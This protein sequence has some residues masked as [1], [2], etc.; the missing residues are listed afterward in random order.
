[1]VKKYFLIASL[2]P[3]LIFGAYLYQ[4]QV[5]EYN[6]T[7]NT[8][9]DNTFALINSRIYDFKVL[10]THLLEIFASDPAIQNSL[11]PDQSSAEIQSIIDRFDA[12]YSADSSMA[13]GLENGSMYTK[14]KALLP[15]DYDPRVRPWYTLTK[16]ATESI[17]LSDPYENA[18]QKSAFSITFSSK[19]FSS[20]DG[21]FIGVAGLDVDMKG[22]LDFGNTLNFPEKTTFFLTDTKGTIIAQVGPDIEDAPRLLATLTLASPHK[23]SSSDHDHRLLTSAG[24]QYAFHYFKNTDTQWYVVAAVEVPLFSAN[25]IIILS[26]ASAIII[27]MTLISIFFARRI[28]NIITDP[29][30]D[31]IEQLTHIN[32]EEDLIPI[33]Q[34]THETIETQMVRDSIN[35]MIQRIS[36]QRDELFDKQFEIQRQY[37]EIEALYEETTAM[38]DTLNELVEKLNDS[39]KQTIRV[40]SNAIEANDEYTR[41]HCDR[42]TQYALA[43]GRQLNIEDSSLEQLEFAALLHDIGK[44][45]IPYHILNKP[46]P[47]DDEERNQ[48]NLH[49]SIGHQIIADVPFLHQIAIYILSHHENYD[50]SGYPNALQDDAIPLASRI[51]RVADA[52]DAMTT[53]RAYRKLPMTWAEAQN[54][55]I[56]HTGTQFDPKVVEAMAQVIKELS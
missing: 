44:V 34:T 12:T 8:L 45:S 47:L 18:T 7:L 32:L 23:P 27:S 11:S 52:F 17:T 38:N 19:V 37:M 29:I 10:N 24:I 51:L 4:S 2:T 6:N 15:A 35:T 53:V 33:P 30:D 46:G 9:I 36:E 41:G 26:V 48:I 55:L 20:D 21:S 40:L 22:L 56:E 16:N 28:D 13:L 50:G 43:I 39:W 3:I 31:M 1:M 42:V 14:N 5:S 25:M 49:P 54:E